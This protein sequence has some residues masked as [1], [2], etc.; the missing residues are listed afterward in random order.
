M[1]SDDDRVDDAGWAAAVR[2]DL[3]RLAQALEHRYD[4]GEPVGRLA[5]ARV[6]AIDALVGRAFRRSLADD[7]RRDDRFSLLATGGYGRGELFPYSD[8]DLLVLT[9]DRLDDDDGERLSRLF[10]LLWDAGVPASHAVRSLSQCREAAAD[11]TV[12][13]ALLELRELAGRQGAAQELAA[14][15]APTRIWPAR[16]YFIA[17]REEQRLRH[18]RFNDTA[19]NLEPNLK[20]GPG[21]LRDLHTLAWMARR[22]HGVPD[23]ASLVPLGSLGEDE[24]ESLEREFGTLARLRYG[25]HLVAGRAEE[26][27]LFDHQ[28]ALAQRLGLKDERRDRLAVEQMMQ[29]FFRAAATVL[30]IND[31]LLQRFEEQLEGEGV[32][33][34]LAEGLLSR[35]GFL[36]MPEPDW[37]VA[38]PDRVLTLF[39]V[40]AAHPGLRGL[41]SET[42]RALAESLPDFPSSD[43]ADDALRARFM[44][45]MRGPAAVKT[46]SRMARLG[47]LARYLPAFG[48][49]AGRMQYDLFHVYT[50]DQHTLEVLRN[51]ESLAERTAAQRFA[52]GPELWSRLRKPELLLLAALFHDIAKGRGGDHSELGAID[53]GDFC[54][55]HGMAPSDT[56]L[57]SWLVGNHLL[58]S[59]TAQRQDISDPDVVARFATRVGDR[60]H[61]DYLYLLTVADIAGTSPKLWNAWKDQLLA[62]LYEATRFALRRGLE[63][64]VFAAERIAET[65]ETARAMLIAQGMAGAEIDRAWQG[66]PEES[67]LRYRPEQVAWQTRGVA[68]LASP[69][70]PL[71]LARPMDE[72]RALE[73]FVYSPDRDG[74]FAA[75]TATLDRMGLSVIAA[76]VL[77]SESGMSL[78]SFQVLATEQQRTDPAELAVMIEKRLGAILARGSDQ[79]RPSRRA[80]PRLLRHFRVPVRIEFGEQGPE[81]SQLTL[82]CTDRPGLLA[83]IAVLFRQH[84][85]RVHDA[86]IATFGERVEDFF[87][88]SDF[89]DR[90]LSVFTTQTLTQAL[91]ACV[92]GG[93]PHGK[94]ESGE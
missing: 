92:E 55:A 28:K 67:F 78:D 22:I 73:V 24:F 37:L 45:L 19:Y 35:R 29:E 60:E 20:D 1:I 82:V 14:A 33:Q 4:A 32:P 17:K 75:V 50:V 62:D 93:Y 27:L 87:L 41:H 48:A 31:R 63:H 10:T 21:G 69:R 18:A 43:Q 71:V 15:V 7:P 76:R 34:P 5:R 40:W 91:M 56:A 90:A 3:T 68:G 84:R 66:Y 26:R 54:R 79:V 38:R 9:W 61:L 6:E 11:V 8:V 39:A 59:T 47:V 25:L 52:F 57:V 53:A 65:R 83:E 16:D 2:A 94:S 86:R 13:T 74:L 42:A 30:R 23:L 64:P 81:R 58:M 36:A 89:S 49:V 44:A 46:L 85:V 51:I 77:N 72:Q 88:L 12:M 80:L 70:Q